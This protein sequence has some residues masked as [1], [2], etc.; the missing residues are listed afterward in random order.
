M[1][2]VWHKLSFVQVSNNRKVEW[3]KLYKWWHGRILG[4]AGKWSKWSPLIER[5]QVLDCWPQSN[6]LLLDYRNGLRIPSG[7]SN[8][9]FEPTLSSKP[10]GCCL[11]LSTSFVWWIATW[12][13]PWRH[14]I[15]PEVG[16][17]SSFQVVDRIEVGNLR[18]WEGEGVTIGTNKIKGFQCLSIANDCYKVSF[19]V[20]IHLLSRTIFNSKLPFQ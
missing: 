13:T 12:E 19:E 3:C 20:I 14:V 4:L 8:F 11:Y 15:T 16:F 18:E 17:E 1:P 6:R 5:Q 9:L 2:H 10:R 7:Q